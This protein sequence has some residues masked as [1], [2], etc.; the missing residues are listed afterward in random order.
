MRCKG[1]G[2]S[3][4]PAAADRQPTGPSAPPGHLHLDRTVRLDIRPASRHDHTAVAWDPDPQPA[5]SVVRA[6]R[7]VDC[8]APTVRPRRNTLFSRRTRIGDA[9]TRSIRTHRKP[10]P[11][12]HAPRDRKHRDR[13]HE[14]RVHPTEPTPKRRRRFRG[15]TGEV[16]GKSPFS[17]GRWRGQHR[18]VL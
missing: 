13:K 4:Q 15:R 14:T 5:V 12:R 11:R 18:P 7:I 10:P 3:V 2:R 17:N 9:R 16:P 8:R 1:C 6:G